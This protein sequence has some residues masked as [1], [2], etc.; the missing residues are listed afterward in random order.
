MPKLANLAEE[1][2][3]PLPRR[4]E[5]TMHA[6]AALKE[7][8]ELSKLDRLPLARTETEEFARA[9]MEFLLKKDQSSWEGAEQAYLAQFTLN[10]VLMNHAYQGRLRQLLPERA[11]PKRL[12]SPLSLPEGGFNPGQ[13]LKKLRDAGIE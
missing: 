6:E 1:M 9:R 5:V 3:K 12:N 8:S 11:F 2:E 7:F 13:F 4:S 10:Q